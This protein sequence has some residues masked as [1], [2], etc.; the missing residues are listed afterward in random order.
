MNPQSCP[1]GRPDAIRANDHIV[2]C[3]I[4]VL[5]GDSASLS[6][7]V[8]CLYK[9]ASSTNA[10]SRAFH[11]VSDHQSSRCA[12]TVLIE[13]TV[14]ERLVHILAVEHVVYLLACQYPLL[15]FN[16]YRQLT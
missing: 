2:F 8:L 13:C 7:N 9:S 15:L 6:V 10:Q 14:H 4:A 16:A 11:L 1:H 3:R 5:K 12:L